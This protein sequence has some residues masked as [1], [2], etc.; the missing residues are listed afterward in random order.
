MRITPEMIEAGARALHGVERT[1]LAA[2]NTILESWE[3]MTEVSREAYREEA[4][5][6]LEAALGR[7]ADAANR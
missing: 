4:R 1:R 2:W 3:E 5:T 7:D 6:C